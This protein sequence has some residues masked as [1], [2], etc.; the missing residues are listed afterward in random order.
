MK[1]AAWPPNRRGSWSRSGCRSLRQ[2]KRGVC[3]NRSRASCRPTSCWLATAT[4]IRPRG[5]RPLGAARHQPVRDPS[6]SRSCGS[7]IRSRFWRANAARRSASAISSLPPAGCT[8][9]WCW[10]AATGAAACSEPTPRPKAEGP[11]DAPIL[12]AADP[13]GIDRLYVLHACHPHELERESRRGR[14]FPQSAGNDA[15]S[16][17]QASSPGS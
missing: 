6:K 3:S 2:P 14:R 8:A 9:A 7:S 11:P 1:S 13:R 4:G 16:G 10:F 17:L 12:L 15:A 5:P